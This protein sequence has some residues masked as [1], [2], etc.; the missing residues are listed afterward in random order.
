MPATVNNLQCEL[1]AKFRFAKTRVEWKKELEKCKYIL[2][3]CTLPMINKFQLYCWKLQWPLAVKIEKLVC[4]LPI[5]LREFVVSRA[6]TTFAEVTES[7]K[8]YQEL[9]EVDI[10]SHVFK[11]VT[12]NDVGCTLCNEA[13]KSLDCPSLR[14]IIEMEVSSSASHIGSSSSSDSCSHSPTHDFSSCRCRF[15]HRSHSASRS[16][17]HFDRGRSP[18]FD[19]SRGR[20]YRYKFPDRYNDY[21]DRQYHPSYNDRRY[22]NSNG[23]SL[24]SGHCQDRY[25]YQHQNSQFQDRYQSG[26]YRNNPNNS[27]GWNQGSQRGRKRQFHNQQQYARNNQGRQSYGNQSASFN[28]ND[29]FMGHSSYNSTS[30]LCDVSNFVTCDYVTFD[31]RQNQGFPKACTVK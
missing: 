23:F 14:S 10:V 20:D 22:C 19:Y 29:K 4:I 5:Q 27:Y 13:H 24:V 31:A 15:T 3:T 25:P 26:N 11:N 28:G 16:H 8:T 18:D 2:G 30:S 12:F 9:I 17:R 1:F 21:R 7:V 6:H